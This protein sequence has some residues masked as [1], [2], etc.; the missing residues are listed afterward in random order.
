MSVLTATIDAANEWT[1]WRA[2]HRSG[3][4]TFVIDDTTAGTVWTA[5]TT[6]VTVQVKPIDAEDAAAIN[7]LRLTKTDVL[8]RLQRIAV[9]GGFAVRMGIK[10][11]EHTA[12]DVI[13]ILY[14]Q[15]RAV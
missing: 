2:F 1:P 7:V 8:S 5:A 9:D 4:S 10:A 14:T 12:S 13:K 6:F 11:G 15:E 3:T